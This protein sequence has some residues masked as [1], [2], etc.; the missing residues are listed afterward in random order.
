MNPDSLPDSFKLASEDY[1]LPR[2]RIPAHDYHGLKVEE[3]LVKFVSDYSVA[4]RLPPE[5]QQ[6]RVIHGYGSTGYG[7]RIKTILREMLTFE[8]V[9]G[10]LTFRESEYLD[11]HPGYT[12]ISP[13]SDLHP[14]PASTFSSPLS[15]RDMGRSI[16]RINALIDSH[17]TKTPTP[18][19]KYPALN[20]QALD[21]LSHV[22][23]KNFD[24]NRNA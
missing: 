24:Q 9:A 23:D 19:T 14:I 5:S 18:L 15:S 4:L 1:V 20:T 3:A 13:I 12:I 17:Q 22:F 21:D 11:R 7:G 6:F 10:V 8:M 2:E 16:R